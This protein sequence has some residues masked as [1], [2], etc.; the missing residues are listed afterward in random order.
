[1][2]AVF[3]LVQVEDAAKSQSTV[4]YGVA[5]DLAPKRRKYRSTQ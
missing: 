1:M 4:V 5:S 2:E 3:W